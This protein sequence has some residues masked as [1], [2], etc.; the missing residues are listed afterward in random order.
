[1]KLGVNREEQKVQ[2]KYTIG[3]I[4]LEYPYHV[5]VIRTAFSTKE[6]PNIFDELNDEVMLAVSEILSPYDADGEFRIPALSDDFTNA[7]E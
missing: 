5:P 2:A 4:I 1:M 7:L 3:S 6:L